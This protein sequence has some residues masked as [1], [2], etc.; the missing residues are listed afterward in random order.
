MFTWL[1]R[2]SLKSSTRFI[3][4]SLLMW[5]KM[6]L[7]WYVKSLSARAFRLARCLVS[8]NSQLS[9]SGSRRRYRSPKISFAMFVEAWD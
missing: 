7:D 6:A 2:N 4:M 3:L 9:I 1:D 8:S 5:S